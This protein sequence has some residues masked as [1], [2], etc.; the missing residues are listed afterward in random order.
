LFNTSVS[1]KSIVS[2]QTLLVVSGEP[3][4][5]FTGAYFSCSKS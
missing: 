2:P 5:V 1:I 3:G 4:V